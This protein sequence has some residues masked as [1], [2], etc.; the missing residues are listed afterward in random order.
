MQAVCGAGLTCGGETLGRSS[1]LGGRYQREEN[2]WADLRGLML[3]HHLV[4]GIREGTKSCAKNHGDYHP[5]L[6]YWF[7]GFVATKYHKL[8]G[9]KQQEFNFSQFW[10]SEA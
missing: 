10:R 6:V 2:S 4:K 5:D 3:M 8:G 9:L 7:S 1:N